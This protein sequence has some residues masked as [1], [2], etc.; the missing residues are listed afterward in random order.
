MLEPLRVFTGNPETV[1]GPDT[2]LLSIKTR[3]GLV[4]VLSPR[5]ATMKPTSGEIPLF[6]I[7]ATWVT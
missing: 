5:V 7:A 6:I 4:L 3:S 2:F 1:S